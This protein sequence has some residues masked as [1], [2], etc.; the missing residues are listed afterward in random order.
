MLP[1]LTEVS[2]SANFRG[3]TQKSETVSWVGHPSGFERV[4]TT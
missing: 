4:G 2:E 1:L 3:Q